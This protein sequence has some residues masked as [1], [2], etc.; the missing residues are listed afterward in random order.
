MTERTAEQIA[1]DNKLEDAIAAA[2]KAYDLVDDGSVVTTWAIIGAAQ[3]LDAG[4]T[5]YFQLF[6]SGV[7][8]LYVTIGLLRLS[9]AELMR[10]GDED[11]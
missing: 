11:G 1:A 8:P 5:G 6:P 7:Q 3:G 10:S 4:R 2:I 9:E